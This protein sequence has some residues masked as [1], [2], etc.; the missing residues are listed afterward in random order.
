MK[1]GDLQAKSV[2]K[3]RELLSSIEKMLKVQRY[4]NTML[5]F[6]EQLFENR[7]FYR[8]LLKLELIDQMP[9][10]KEKENEDA[11]FWWSIEDENCFTTVFGE[12]INGRAHC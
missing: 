3:R 7:W 12:E 1:L 6:D 8:K 2:K 5:T 11:K 10:G 9:D 4:K